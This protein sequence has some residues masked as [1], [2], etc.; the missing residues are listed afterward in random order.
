MTVIKKLRVYRVFDRALTMACKMAECGKS[1]FFGGKRRLAMKD[2]LCSIRDPQGSHL[3]KTS[4][5]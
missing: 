5:L 4:T 2:G 1:G 3:K